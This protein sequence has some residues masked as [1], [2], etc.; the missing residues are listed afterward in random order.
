MFAA[1]TLGIGVDFAVHLLDAIRRRDGAVGPA[2][3]EV[4]PAITLDV[5]ALAG[6]F[7][8]LLLSQVPATR[9]LGLLICTTLFGCALLTL[10]LVPA[11]IFRARKSGRP[12]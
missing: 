3:R 7:S 1:M 6:A 8:V 11:L 4:G 2:L 9:H 5:L 10:F 12:G